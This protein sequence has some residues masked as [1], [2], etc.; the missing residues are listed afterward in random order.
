MEY[1]WESIVVSI[2][3]IL[4]AIVVVVLCA[5]WG[6][7]CGGGGLCCGRR[8]QKSKPLLP[9]SIQHALTQLEAVT[10]KRSV[11]NSQTESEEAECP[12]CLAYLYPLEARTYTPTEGNKADL[13]A[14]NGVSRTTTST[15]EV[16]TDKKNQQPIQPIDDEVLKLKRCSH[17]FHARCLATWFLRKKYDCPVCRAPFYQVTPEM[18][19]DEDYRVPPTL[20]TVAFW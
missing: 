14:G 2:I 8:G 1:P 17:I 11:R 6:G 7:L 3:V 12:I 15:T 4:G 16:A 13:E 18:V 9:K 10:E 20:P 5:R 19:P